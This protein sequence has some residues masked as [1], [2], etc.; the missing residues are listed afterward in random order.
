LH[1][2]RQMFQVF[3]TSHDH[4]GCRR[5]SLGPDD[6]SENRWLSRAFQLDFLK[7]ISMYQQ[8]NLDKTHDH[9]CTVASSESFAI[10]G[11]WPVD[12]FANLAFSLTSIGNGNTNLSHQALFTLSLYS[13]EHRFNYLVVDTQLHDLSGRKLGQALRCNGFPSFGVGAHLAIL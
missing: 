2:T 1:L 11:D 5:A 4:R 9:P 13:Q 6:S 12:V 7:K 8:S 10:C 3:I